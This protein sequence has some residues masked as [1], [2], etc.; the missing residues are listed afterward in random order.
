MSG[1]LEVR[2][3]AIPGVLELMPKS[4]GDGRGYFREAYNRKRFQEETGVAIDFVQSNQSYSAERGTLRGLHFQAPPFAQAKLVWA[5]RGAVFDV[6]VDIRF[7]S[8]TYGRWVSVVLVAERGN[9][10]LVPAGFAHGFVTL[11]AN[12]SVQYM[13]DNHYAPSAEGGLRWDDPVLAIDWPLDGAAPTLTARD[14]DFPSLAD[15]ATPF[16][17]ERNAA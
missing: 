17:F 14:D 11:E 1:L 5:V 13:V 10:I 16:S 2:P 3:L 12:T 7:G 6:A 4:F 15:L 8:P 9:Q